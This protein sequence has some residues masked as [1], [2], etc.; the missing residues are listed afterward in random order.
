MLQNIRVVALSATL[1]N[2]KDVAAFLRI[3]VPSAEEEAALGPQKSPGLF[4]FD[5]SYRPVPLKQQYIGVSEKKA[6]KR[7]MLMN[8]ITYEKVMERAARSQII[9]FVH[10]RKETGRTAR[11]IKD[12]ALN[13]D[14]LAGLIGGSS[15]G[16]KYDADYM[17][18]IA[19]LTKSQELQELVPYAIGIHHAGLSRGDRT[20]VEELFA[21]K[22]L[23]V[24]VAT[25]TLAYGVNLPA[26][27][28]I[29]KGT[30]IYSA[31][32]G[33]WVD[34]SGQDILQMI[35]RAGRF[36]LDPYGEGILLTSR[37]SMESYLTILNS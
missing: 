26:R 12:A 6:V 13:R 22:R 27:T 15:S 28:V 23:R 9:V 5:K 2:Y 3:Q 7:M 36:G 16:E 37:G 34:L 18:K 35:G 30:Q 25:A 20:L 24:L 1:P 4:Y 19:K 17:Q 33:S 32:K 8:E 10:S 31:Q 21:D 14:E 11:A 29:I